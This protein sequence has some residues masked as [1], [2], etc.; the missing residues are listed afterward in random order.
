M[1]KDSAPSSYV[2]LYHFCQN[3][4]SLSDIWSVQS[5]D[6]RNIQRNVYYAYEA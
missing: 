1:K 4:G 2:Y 6:K 5:S 3:Y